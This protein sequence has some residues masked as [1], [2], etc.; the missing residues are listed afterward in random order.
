MDTFIFERKKIRRD[1][2]VA[3]P[4][5]KKTREMKNCV[6]DCGYS[7]EGGR[8]TTLRDKRCELYKFILK[9]EQQKQQ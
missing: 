5:E 6:Y 1:R 2:F 8:K 7:L 4:R 9:K 3:T